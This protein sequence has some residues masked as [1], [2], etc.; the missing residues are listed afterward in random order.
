[1]FIYMYLLEVFSTK[2]TL[3]INFRLVNDLNMN[4]FI[5]AIS[6]CDW[7]SLRCSDLN[8]FTENLMNKLGLFFCKYFPL[9]VKCIKYRDHNNPWV[10][11]SLSKLIY[12]YIYLYIYI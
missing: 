1:M 5:I 10:T 7:N 3:K 11:R 2:I 4:N 12:I 6:N 9:K 8:K